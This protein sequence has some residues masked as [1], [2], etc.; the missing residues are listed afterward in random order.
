MQC[1]VAV[2]EVFY[3]IRAIHN[4]NHKLRHLKSNRIV[5]EYL[6]CTYNKLSGKD[7]DGIGD[8]AI[9]YGQP[10]VNS[11]LTN[12]TKEPKCQSLMYTSSEQRCIYK[13]E[14]Q[15]TK[16]Q[17]LTGTNEKNALYSIN[18]DK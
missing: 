17:S 15:Y 3:T 12:C 8:L 9:V 5:F 4:R 6:A 11:C 14:S 7:L 16:P 13:A 2:V 1:H 10:D 18:C